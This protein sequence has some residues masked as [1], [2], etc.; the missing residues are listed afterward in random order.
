MKRKLRLIAAMTAMTFGGMLLIPT[1]YAQVKIGT[2]P[3]VI[4][5][6][7]NL[8]IE[9]STSGRKVSVN[10]TTGQLTVKDGTE[11]AGK[12]LTSDANGNAEWK[13]AGPEQTVKYAFRSRKVD[14]VDVAAGQGDFVYNGYETS[15]AEAARRFNIGNRFDPASGKF[16]APRKGYYMF[17]AGIRIEVSGGAA[18]PARKVKAYVARISNGLRV[19]ERG[20]VGEAELSD[21]KYSY[22]LSTL[23]LLEENDQVQIEIWKTSGEPPYKITSGFFEGITVGAF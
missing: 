7:S 1:C 4:D 15:N 23:Y 13:P 11:G 18:I 20:I 9:A 8:E 19:D 6:N 21:G 14:G 5:G 16:T 12:V 22:N 3:T 2:N 10:K 17:N